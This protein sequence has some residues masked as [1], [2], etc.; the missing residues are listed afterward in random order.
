[1][2]LQETFEIYKTNNTYLPKP[3][4]RKELVFASDE[5]L[6]NY[7]SFDVEFFEKILDIDFYDRFF[8]DKSC[9]NIL[10]CDYDDD[11]TIKQ[12]ISNKVKLTYGANI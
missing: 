6:L 8:S 4:E 2:K 12:G 1:M 10:Y 5:R 9:L 7:E 3:W 11:K